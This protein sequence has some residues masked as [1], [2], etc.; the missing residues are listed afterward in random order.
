MASHRNCCAGAANLQY[1]LDF[2]EDDVFLS[3]VPLHHILGTI[4]D[5]IMPMSVGA[6]V[7]YCEG[8][9]H[10]PRNIKETR[11]TTL[12]TA[13]AIVEGIYKQIWFTLKKTGKAEQ[14]QQLIA[15][16][17]FSLE[18]SREVFKEIYDGVLGGRLKMFANGGAA[19]SPEVV[20]GWRDFGVLALT[21]WGLTETLAPISCEGP[22]HIRNNSAGLI[23]PNTEWK[24]LNPDENGHGEIVIKGPSVM[25]GYYEDEEATKEAFTEDRYLHTGDFVNVD[26]DNFIYILGRLKNI[27]KT[28]NG[29]LV[30]P[31]ELELLLT[32][33]PYVKECLV[34]AK[35]ME[36]SDDSVVATSVFPDKDAIREKF[37][38]IDDAQIVKIM[39]E[40]I[41]SFNSDMPP[42]KVIW[43]VTVRDTEFEKTPSRK[44]K[45]YGDNLPPQA[46]H[47]ASMA[48][49]VQDISTSNTAPKA[50][51]DLR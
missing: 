8:L 39:N 10:L 4:G 17:N 49:S 37:G 15:E 28:K 30:F 31:E 26:K 5:F 21:G 43:D 27:I 3:I 18:Q 50:D 22:E 1:T 14:I 19:I 34:F 11:P 45:R 33:N 23:V 35:A 47:T 13:P 40:Q 6:S 32:A 42:S 24:I 46:A 7:S 16:N 9:Q 29:E 38:D 20:K 41:Q 12:F 51:H 36:G 25:L 48:G 2:N 44:I